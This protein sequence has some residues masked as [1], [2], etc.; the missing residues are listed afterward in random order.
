MSHSPE[1][2]GCCLFVVV[3]FGLLYLSSLGASI[4]HRGAHVASRKKPGRHQF[5]YMLRLLQLR[6]DASHATSRNKNLVK[7]RCSHF[8]PVQLHSWY[9]ILQLHCVVMDMQL[10]PTTPLPQLQSLCV[11]AVVVWLQHLQLHV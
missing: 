4:A 1:P 6:M 7:P 8:V 10:F 2:L 9:N 5:L 11:Y 3:Q